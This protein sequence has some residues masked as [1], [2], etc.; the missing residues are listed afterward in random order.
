MSVLPT[1]YM[2][3]TYIPSD[4]GGWKT[5]DNL[6][7]DQE[8]MSCQMWGLYTK[9]GSFTGATSA[10]NMSHLLQPSDSCKT[11]SQVTLHIL[12]VFYG[13][14][15]TSWFTSLVV[16]ELNLSPVMPRLTWVVFKKTSPQALWRLTVA[17]LGSS[18]WR[19]C[20]TSGEKKK[21]GKL[22]GIVRKWRIKIWK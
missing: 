12:Y 11:P 1:W 8:V 7:L 14:I 9:P 3:I 13:E 15:L 20:R 17:M 5:S 22:A 2:C 16:I 10:L 18:G 4:W 6:E 21:M 19:H